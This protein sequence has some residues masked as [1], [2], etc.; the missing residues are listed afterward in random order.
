MTNKKFYSQV[1]MAFCHFPKEGES[2]EAYRHYLIITL[3]DI[4]ERYNG[5]IDLSDFAKL[6][7]GVSLPTK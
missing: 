7:G 2:A 3:A 4:F 6:C 1:G 5:D